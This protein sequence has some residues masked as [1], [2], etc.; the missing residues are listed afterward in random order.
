MMD[1]E[2]LKAELKRL[3]EDPGYLSEI[4]EAQIKEAV[5]E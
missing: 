1:Y 3:S 5:K 4:V 2:I